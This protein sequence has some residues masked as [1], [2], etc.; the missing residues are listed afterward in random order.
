MQQNLALGFIKP[1]ASKSAATWASVRTA[2]ER[3]GV[4]V[5][6][7]AWVSAE[8]IRD[9]GLIDRHYAVIARIGGC[10]DPQRLELDDQARAAFQTAFGVAWDAACRQGSVVS[11]MDALRRL[12]VTA[13]DLMT[14]WSKIKASKIGPGFYAAMIEG[15]YVL[16]G[17]YPSIREIYTEDGAGIRCFLMAFDGAT[18]PWKAFR[19]NVIG[20]TD[21]AKAAAGSVRGELL[22]RQ[23]EFGLHLNARDNVIHASASPFEALMERLIWVPG[24][25][26]A[27]DPLVKAVSGAGITVA[28]LSD[29]ARRNPILSRDGKTASAIDH[30]EDLD[31]PAAA[32]IL[33]GWLAGA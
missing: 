31:T 4:R 16:N 2:L 30:L 5:S 22:K 7:D 24:F 9:Q 28:M 3:H 13:T 15:V 33:R 12:K 14:A 21:P 1:H 19:A 26:P 8:A 20:A 27:A 10:P 17:F 32:A 29:L 11:G 23:D 25:D 6:A 18:L